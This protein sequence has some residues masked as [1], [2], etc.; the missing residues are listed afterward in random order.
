MDPMDRFCNEDERF[1]SACEVLGVLGFKCA[2][3]STQQNSGY[4]QIPSDAQWEIAA[5]R[6][7]T[8]RRY[9]I[10]KSRQGKT[11]RGAARRSEARRGEA[12]RGEARRGEARSGK[13]RQGKDRQ[14]DANYLFIYFTGV[15]T[16]LAHG[17]R[18][19]QDAPDEWSVW[20]TEAIT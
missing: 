17:R 9:K 8:T 12:R 5:T 1:G 19:A 6:Q 10:N 3:S 4:A 16:A 20:F 2:K 14:G 7:D 15:L 18:L 11:R 13:I